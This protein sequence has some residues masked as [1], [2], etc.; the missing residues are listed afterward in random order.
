VLIE[1][2]TRAR[3]G[4]TV[5]EERID[6]PPPRIAIPREKYVVEVERASEAELYEAFTAPPVE[7][8]QRRY[9]LDEVRY[10]QPLRERVRR[11]DV[12]TVTFDSGSWLI[13]EAQTGA[14]TG[15]ANAIRRAIEG[16]PA[17]VFLVEGHTDAVGADID[18]LTLS[19]RRA[20]TVAAILSE[21]FGVPAENL[22]TQG[23]GEQYLKV[24][25]EGPERQNRRVTIRRIT[26]LLRG[27]EAQ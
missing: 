13:D 14:L 6:L 7:R 4:R 2:E 17:E 1:N 15:V 3:P 16:N 19:D 26:P 20:E 5:I 18:N 27:A 24:S 12:D 11:V 21:R 8:I 10:N 23:Y 9:S 25:T 22:T